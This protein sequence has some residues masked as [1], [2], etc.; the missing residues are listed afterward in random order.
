[1]AIKKE[2][3]VQA[4]KTR[5][6]TITTANG[7]HTNLGNN[8]YEWKQNPHADTNTLSAVIRDTECEEVN[9]LDQAA[10]GIHTKILTMEIEII[11]ASG[12]PAQDLRKAEADV[13]KAIGTDTTFGGLA[14]DTEPVNSIPLYPNQNEK[15][16]AGLQRTV[17]ITFRT[18]A[19]QES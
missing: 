1:M 18:T 7:Y 15:R 17:E 8:I 12:T 19:W 5:L 16:I 6:E 10:S 14:V 13:N 3:I 2:Q 11:A 9:V 4:V